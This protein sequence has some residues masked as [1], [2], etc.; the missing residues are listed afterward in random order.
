[1]MVIRGIKGQKGVVVQLGFAV[2]IYDDLVLRVWRL[3]KV[4]NRERNFVRRLDY[5]S[6]WEF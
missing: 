3:V 1:M 4:L 2:M 5:L 6:G